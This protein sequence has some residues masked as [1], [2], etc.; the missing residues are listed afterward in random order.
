MTAELRSWPGTYKCINPT[1][2]PIQFTYINRD[3]EKLPSHREKPG[4][5]ASKI[6]SKTHTY[7]HF[8]SCTA[9]STG[10]T[11]YGKLALGE[12]WKIKVRFTV[13]DL[14]N[15]SLKRCCQ[16]DYV[17]SSSLLFSVL[18]SLTHQLLISDLKPLLKT[19]EHRWT[20]ELM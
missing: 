10:H 11:R 1:Q 13:V 20:S 14:P 7:F 2:C 19:L 17:T 12:I 8:C 4:Q 6:K 5:S 9:V 18:H 3:E 15:D 16:P